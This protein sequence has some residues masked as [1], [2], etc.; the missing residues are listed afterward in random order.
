MQFSALFSLIHRRP[1]P[2]G[3][4]FE[5]DTNASQLAN[6]YM[7]Y[8]TYADKDVLQILQRHSEETS[9]CNYRYVTLEVLSFVVTKEVNN[10]SCNDCD[11]KYSDELFQITQ[12]M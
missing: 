7:Q 12:G 1:S 8:S 10:L 3:S 2:K 4:L 11:Y 9:E 6:F 5:L